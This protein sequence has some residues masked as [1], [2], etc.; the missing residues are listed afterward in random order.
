MGENFFLSF[1]GDV[2]VQ[3]T[4][5]D[6]PTQLKGR[7]SEER[8]QEATKKKEKSEA[9]LYT[10][11]VVRLLK[12]S[13]FAETELDFEHVKLV[14]D[15]SRRLFRRTSRIRSNGFGNGGETFP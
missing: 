3:V 1:P 11:V 8:E 2:L 5:K 9:H 13:P 4:E 10:N 6:I 15:R 12:D 7:L 14:P